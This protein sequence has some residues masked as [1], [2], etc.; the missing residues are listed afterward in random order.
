MRRCDVTSAEMDELVRRANASGFDSIA[1]YTVSLEDTVHLL[2]RELSALV[3][4]V[5]RLPSLRAERL[6]YEVDRKARGEA[7]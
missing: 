3:D 1:E 5:H 7:A 2:C 4:G 6:L